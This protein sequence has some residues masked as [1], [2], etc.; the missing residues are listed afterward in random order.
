VLL[1]NAD[2]AEISP[3]KLRD[4]LLSSGHPIGRFKARVFTALGFSAE[5][6]QELERALREQHLTE[7]AEL[8]ATVAHG[9]KYTIRAILEGPGGES[10]MIVSVWFV[11]T[12]AD[13]PRFVTAYPGEGQ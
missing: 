6:W 9:R 10:A 1:P 2:R 5:R 8:S 3:A 12:G 7:D 11:P 4:Y 13:I